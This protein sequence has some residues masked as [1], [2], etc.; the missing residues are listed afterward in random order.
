MSV[1]ALTQVE[2]A[3]GVPTAH[4]PGDPCRLNDATD[5]GMEVIGRYQEARHAV[6]YDLAQP[7]AAERNDGSAA[8]VRFGGSHP[9]GLIPLGREQDDGSSGHRLPQSFPR[10]GAV[11]RHAGQA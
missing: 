1:Q 8:G 2:V 6:R 5:A 11:N 9:E 7:A 3:L 10:D 4:R